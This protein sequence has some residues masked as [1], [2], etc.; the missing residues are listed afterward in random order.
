MDWIFFGYNL[1]VVNCVGTQIPLKDIP[2]GT[3][4]PLKETKKILE[5]ESYKQVYTSTMGSLEKK[6]MTRDENYKIGTH[7]NR[8]AI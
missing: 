3:G 5:D 4:E 8:R 2:S 7:D 1:S 6:D